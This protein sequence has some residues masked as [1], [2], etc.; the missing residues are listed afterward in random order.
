MKRAGRT[1]IVGEKEWFG[2][3]QQRDV[4]EQ[5]KQGVVVTAGPEFPDFVTFSYIAHFVEVRIDPRI[6]RPR[7]S[8]VREYRRLWPGGQ[9]ANGNQ[10]GVRWSRVGRR[11]GAIGQSEIDP[12]FGGFL[13]TN[14][15]EY[16]IPVNADIG[17]IEVDF[18]D[19]PDTK[20]NAVG[21]KSLG[22]VAS[23]GVAAAIANAV[24]HATGKRLRD[25]PIRIENLL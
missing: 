25:L 1:N 16:Q 24:Y 6:C 20:F 2:A 9:P 17:S 13:N 22:E 14:I 23:A 11:Y 19:E 4:I 18:V 7:V 3:G 8:R 12:R 15:A 21:A 10:P 5:A